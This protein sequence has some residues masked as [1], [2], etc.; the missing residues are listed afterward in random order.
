MFF[1][2]LTG[3]FHML[4]HINVR[5]ILASTLTSHFSTKLMRENCLM[6]SRTTLFLTSTFTLTSRK[7]NKIVCLMQLIE[8][9][10]NFFILTSLFPWAQLKT[11]NVDYV[12][13]CD[14]WLIPRATLYQHAR[15]PRKYTISRFNQKLM[16]K[17]CFCCFRRGQVENK[18]LYLLL[19]NKS[20]K[21][22]Y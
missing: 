4:R 11:A 16:W 21:S 9:F 8:F 2:V 20:R 18:L 1:F 7:Y 14:N 15:N 17:N 22:F 12:I 13:F 3:S 19:L 10:Y 5:A 6:F